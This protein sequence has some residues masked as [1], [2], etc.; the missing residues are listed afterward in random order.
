MKVL[1]ESDDNG[2]Y[3]FHW[4]F[5]LDRQALEFYATDPD[6]FIDTVMSRLR[7]KV[8]ISLQSYIELDDDRN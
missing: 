4:D 1:M 5:P 7:H 6:G 2:L 8:E 3:W